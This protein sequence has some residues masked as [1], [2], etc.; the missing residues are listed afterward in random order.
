MTASH[1]D[2]TTF[3]AY[4]E[5]YDALYADKDYEA[6]VDFLESVFSAYARGDVRTVLDLG[7]GTGGH[8]VP[9]AARGY[10]VTG[11]DRAPAMVAQ[12]REKAT[13]A[14]V[15][16]RFEVADVRDYDLGETFDAVVSMFAVVSYQLTGDDVTAMFRAARAH[17][18]PGGLLV[19]DGWFGPAV[20]AQRPRVSEKVVETPGGDVVRRRAVPSVDEDAQTVTV[21]YRVERVSGAAVT[22]ATD[23]AHTVRYLFADEIEQHCRDAG[24]ELVALGPFG[25]LSRGP[26]EDDWNFSAVA[27]AR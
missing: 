18:S 13:A 4:A 6:E 20:L 8:A 26:G 19:F 2:E 27:R 15:D 3:G 11:L 16:P 23:E 7:C 9:L 21:S 22:A 17:L 10:R 12:A 25:D 24:F 14:C 5:F 1:A